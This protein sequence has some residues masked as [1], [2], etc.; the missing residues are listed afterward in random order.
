MS[1]YDLPDVI[2]ISEDGPI[3]I[4]RLNR[5]DDL[6][7][8]NHELHHASQTC[9]PSSTRTTVRVPRSLPATAARSPPAATSRTSTS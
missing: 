2:E 3:R 8:T 4:V 6:N 7:A 5:P 9:S 1:H